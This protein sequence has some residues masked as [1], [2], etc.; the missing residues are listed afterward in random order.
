MPTSKFPF[1]GFVKKKVKYSKKKKYKSILET[2]RQRSLKGRNTTTKYSFNLIAT[3]LSNCAVLSTSITKHVSH[4]SGMGDTWC[5]THNAETSCK[6]PHHRRCIRVC[7]CDQ[8]VRGSLVSVS[9]HVHSSTV[10]SQW[11]SI[12]LKDEEKYTVIIWKTRRT[13]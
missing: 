13:T 6:V 11:Y 9:A 12:P 5:P 7:V 3:V 8:I 1:V 10:I 2:I 4:L